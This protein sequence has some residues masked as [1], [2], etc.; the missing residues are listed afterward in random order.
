[1]RA[2]YLTYAALAVTHLVCV[3]VGFW[4]RTRLTEDSDSTA[5]QRRDH[6]VRSLNAVIL[7]TVDLA[8]LNMARAV[9]EHRITQLLSRA[10]HA[11]LLHR[12]SDQP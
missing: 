6:A 12:Q 8:H 2:A 9:R 4:L 11:T 3:A 5:R 1:M 10:E 7:E